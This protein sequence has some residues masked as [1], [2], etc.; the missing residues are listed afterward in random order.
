MG[1]GGVDGPVSD[2]VNGG[3]VFASYSDGLLNII[4]KH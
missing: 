1:L 2:A 3:S 4:R